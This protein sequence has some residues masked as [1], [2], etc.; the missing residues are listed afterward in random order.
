MP[1]PAFA[2]RGRRTSAHRPASSIPNF[3]VRRRRWAPAIGL[4]SPEG[5]SNARNPPK[6]SEL[7]RPSVTNSPSASS[8]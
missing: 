3:A 2:G 5:T 7:T 6:L 8:I 1:A 4:R